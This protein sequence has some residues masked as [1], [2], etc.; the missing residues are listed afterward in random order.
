MHNQQL[1]M[2]TALEVNTSDFQI[3][4]LGNPNNMF[5]LLFAL[6]TGYAIGRAVSS[7]KAA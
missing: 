5:M 6:G 3:R 4:L 1:P 7:N 2:Q